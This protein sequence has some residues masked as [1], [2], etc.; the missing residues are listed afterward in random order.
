MKARVVVTLALFTAFCAC[1]KKD[2]KDGDG[3]GGDKDCGPAEVIADG[4][5]FEIKKT[6]AVYEP[7]AKVTM[8]YG[9]NY[10]SA[11]CESAI[12]GMFQHP[13]GGV[14]F[15]MSD[16]STDAV[17]IGAHTQMGGAYR[18]R[19]PRR[20]TSPVIRSRSASRRSP[21]SQPSARSRAKT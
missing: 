6:L 2:G 13:E 8:V 12:S 20:P 7:K 4:K 10:D 14:S 18:S 16:S 19:P 11:K 21:S 1:N 5:P 15:R 17:G 3:E 9:F